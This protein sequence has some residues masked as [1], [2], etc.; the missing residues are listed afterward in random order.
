[1][2]IGWATIPLIV[3]YTVLVVLYIRLAKREE[4]DMEAEF[5]DEYTR[6]RKRTKMFIPFVY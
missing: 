3:L 6:Y 4:K 1:M 2:M 5:G